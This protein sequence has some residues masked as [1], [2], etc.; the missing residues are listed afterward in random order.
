M[1]STLT[2][3]DVVVASIRALEELDLAGLQ[4]STHPDAVNR[5]AAAEPPACRQPG[6]AG[7]YATGQWLHNLA[8]D[9]AWDIHDVVTE[10]DLVALHVTMSGHQSNPHTIYAPDGSP[11]QV[12]PNHGR[13]FAVTQSHWFRLRD[14]LVFE[15]WANR[16]DLGMAMQLGWFEPP[17]EPGENP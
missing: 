14:G 8:S 2:A 5:E 9:I 17:T 13:A 6:P 10:G 7:M 16:D 11:A 1:T 4:A 3:A 12:M 15:H